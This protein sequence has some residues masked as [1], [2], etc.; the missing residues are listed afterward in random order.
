MASLNEALDLIYKKKIKI[1]LTY[2]NVVLIMHFGVVLTIIVY[3][4]FLVEALI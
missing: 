1:L 2:Q 3:V 4:F